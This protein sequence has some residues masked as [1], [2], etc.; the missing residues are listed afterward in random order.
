MPDG[1]ADICG[2]LGMPGQATTTG[3]AEYST[4]TGKVT[5]VLGRWTFGPAQVGALAINVFWSN[6]SGSVLI[7][8]I[9]EGMGKL[10]VISGGTF[11]PLPMPPA[12]EAAYSGYW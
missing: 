4:T 8:V 5:R 9:P 1:S 2:E 10:G 7:G 3:F 11:I 6:A 12:L